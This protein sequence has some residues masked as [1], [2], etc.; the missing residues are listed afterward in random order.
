MK[1]KKHWWKILSVLLLLYS[2]V[3]GLIIPLKSGILNLSP[4]VF[5]T[6][7]SIKTLVKTYNTKFDA[8]TD[9]GTF[10]Y[11]KINEKFK[12]Y[13][14]KVR[15]VDESTLELAFDLPALLPQ[16]QKTM[17]YTLIISDPTHGSFVRPD[18]MI[19]KQEKVDLEQAISDWPRQ[20]SKNLIFTEKTKFPF[21]PVLYE[22]IRNTFYHV[23]LWFAMVI[24][25]FGSVIYSI[26]YLL[27]PDHLLDIYARSLTVVG[28]LFGMLGCITGSIWAKGTWGTWWTFAEIKLNVSAIAML[29]YLAYF[30][31]RSALQDNEQKARV[32]AVYSIFAFVI[33][34]PL[35][36][37]VPRMVSSSLHPGNG[38][39]P[40][41]GG[42][43]LDN[44]LRMVFYPAIIGWIL[45]GFWLSQLLNRY[46]VLN[47]QINEEF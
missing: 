37:V 1:M 35:L 32:S 39:N 27:K 24:I 47:E 31:L 9:T 19:L 38:G 7:Q 23:P 11:L 45:M 30:I 46:H 25:F 13:A 6:N 40:G 33:T 26:K 12:L 22:S 18:A 10:A 5:E 20:A 16:V 15:I 43:D 44:T 29:I 41:F 3:V 8:S 42:E 4:N 34:V 17:P 21:R 28:V 2:I 14:N 36:F